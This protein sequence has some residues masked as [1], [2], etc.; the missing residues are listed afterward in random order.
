MI[1]PILFFEDEELTHVRCPR[2][3]LPAVPVKVCWRCPDHNGLKVED[4]DERPTVQCAWGGRLQEAQLLTQQE[5]SRR[6]S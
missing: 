6:G 2:P 3:Y 5:A 4:P 1:P